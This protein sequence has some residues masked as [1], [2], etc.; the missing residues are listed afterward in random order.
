VSPPPPTTNPFHAPDFGED[1][2]FLVEDAQ[3][4]APGIRPARYRA[5]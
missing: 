1:E 3:E 5:A 2:I 4:P